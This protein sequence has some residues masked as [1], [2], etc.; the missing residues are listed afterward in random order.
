MVVLLVIYHGTIREKNTLNKYIDIYIY[1]YIYIKV[2][3]GKLLYFLNL[4]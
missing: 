4:N 3:L 1:M 2:L